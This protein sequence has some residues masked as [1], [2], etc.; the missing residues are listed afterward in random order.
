MNPSIVRP[1]LQR[2]GQSLSSRQRGAALDGAKPPVVLAELLAVHVR[3][4]REHAGEV[5]PQ[6]LVR[7]VEM[8]LG[9]FGKLVRVQ[10]GFLA[11]GGNVLHDLR[12]L[13]ID[14]VEP[15]IDV[16]E[17][18]VELLLQ[19]VEATDKG[20][21]VRFG[22]RCCV[23]L[24]WHGLTRVKEIKTRCKYIEQKSTPLPLPTSRTRLE[25]AVT[26]WVLKTVGM[27]CAWESCM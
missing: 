20:S 22:S 23:I 18:T 12:A 26:A 27:I 7:G 4:L 17:T 19:D 16:L 3:V 6:M 25:A 2:S 21:N 15:P 5:V 1:H 14:G 10:A 9:F 13:F 11:F 8:P 24:V